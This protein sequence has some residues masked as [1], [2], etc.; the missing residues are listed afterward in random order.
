MII[1]WNHTEHK[2]NDM[3]I[4]AYLQGHSIVCS[5]W[6]TTYIKVCLHFS[7]AIP[8]KRNS[9]S[10]DSLQV[11]S[12]HWIIHLLGISAKLILL[13]YLHN[14]FTDLFLAAKDSCVFFFWVACKNRFSS[15]SVHDP[16][17]KKMSS[18]QVGNYEYTEFILQML[19]IN[20]TWRD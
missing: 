8:Y 17:W 20:V 12:T 7:T 6:E 2:H 3:E 10:S 4:S 19:R 11:L 5:T 15:P 16:V 14:I 13:Y 1:H 9:Q 18:L